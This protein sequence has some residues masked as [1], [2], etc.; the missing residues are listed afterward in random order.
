MNGRIRVLVVAQSTGS[1]TTLAAA[2]GSQEGFAVDTTT[3]LPTAFARVGSGDVDCLVTEG[4][5]DAPAVELS[6]RDDADAVR[7]PIVQQPS[8]RAVSSVVD[9]PRA[10]SGTQEHSGH[11]DHGAVQ[12]LADRVRHAVASTRLDDSGLLREIADLSPDAIFRIDHD[13]R[14]TYVSPAVD[15]LLAHSPEDLLGSHF[16]ELVHDADFETA[17]AGFQRVL[18]GDVLRS[19]DVT[20]ETDDGDLVRTEVSAK[21]VY[22]DGDVA[23]VQGFARDVTDRHEARSRLERQE[24]FLQSSPDTFYVLDESGEITYQSHA[25]EEILGYPRRDL[26]G[27]S[28]TPYIHPEDRDRVREDFERLL[29]DGSETVTTEYRYQTISGEWRWME[30]RAINRLDDPTIE[31]VLVVNRDVTTRRRRERELEETTDILSTL[32]ETLPVGVTVIDANGAVARAN[33]RAKTVLG[34]HDV[35]NADLTFDNQPWSLVDADGE[36]VS[37]TTL[38]FQRVLD[39]GEPVFDAEYG[40]RWPDGTERWISMDAVPLDPN[41]PSTLT[42]PTS[43]MTEIRDG[44]SES[45]DPV[46]DSRRVVA[47]IADR[48]AAREDERALK[49]RN[50]R[51]DEF[52]SIVSHDLRNPLAVANGALSLA[53]TDAADGVDDDLET[54]ADALAR[55]EALIDDLLSVARKGEHVVDSEPVTFAALA[56]EAWSTVETGSAT[57]HVDDDAS[58]WADRSRLRQLL[59]NLLRN[60]IDHAGPDATVTAGTVADGFFVEDDGPGI[61]VGDRADIFDTDYSTSGSGRG[62][63]L[64]I[65][66]DVAD[67]HEWRITVEDG[68]EGGARF[69]FTNVR[70]H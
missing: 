65:V 40:L 47:V 55:M 24:S 37:T 48:T 8:H 68:R 15:S 5:A 38:P 58:I 42:S 60:A 18:D 30:N 12:A 53:R 49:A 11:P 31:G 33:Q 70:V 45:G 44:T 62:F 41:R 4:D 22:R 25:S 27:E 16:A 21:P 13:G 57:L 2:L 59:E 19:L 69:E 1:E 46:V 10:G 43:T 66:E 34:L 52:A 9:Q 61:S 26:Q 23:F 64:A 39:A 6:R 32:F 14:I 3:D 36:P 54:V 67:A 63:G 50:E 7:V 29:T 35:S 51:L 20:L 17:A 28:V 56:E